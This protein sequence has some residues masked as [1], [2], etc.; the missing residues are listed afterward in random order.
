MN[1]LTLAISALLLVTA[2]SCR[3]QAQGAQSAAAEE[4]S[5]EAPVRADADSVYAFVKAQTELGPR[6]PGTEAHSRLCAMLQ[7]RVE[8]YGADTVVGQQAPV[9]AWDGTRHT[10]Y[11]I[12]GRFGAGAPG[13]VLLLAHYDTRP[14]ADRDPDEANHSKAIDGANDGASGVAALLEI[15]RVAGRRLPPDTGFDILLVDMEDMGTPAGA[16]S[17]DDDDTWALGAQAWVKDMP[18]TAADRPAFGILL[19][20][21]GGRDARFHREYFSDR[22]AAGIVDKVWSIA[23]LSGLGDRFPNTVGGAIVD[24]HL[25]INGAGIPCIDI[26][27]SSNPE[28]GSFNP[29]WHTMADNLGNIDRRTLRDVTQV[30]LTTLYSVKTR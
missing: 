4:A 13:R 18:Y 5:V 20:M 11:N 8:G 15:A 21:V 12:L 24:D 29:T 22:D 6:V 16:S 10:A 27:E 1:R 23:R 2:C 28:T 3:K 14:W 17:G 26:I 30:V 25:Q 7:Q 9:T 19:D